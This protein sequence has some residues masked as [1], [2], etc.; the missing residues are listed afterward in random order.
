[1]N[2]TFSVYNNSL[3]AMGGWRFLALAMDLWNALIFLPQKLLNKCTLPIMRKRWSSP[4]DLNTKLD[5]EK[6]EPISCSKEARAKVGGECE[7]KP[8]TSEPDD[9]IRLE[10]TIINIINVVD[11]ESDSQ[12]RFY[13]SKIIKCSMRI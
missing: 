4:F 1:V 9:N 6:E 2:S 8:A 11:R 12:N 7:T 10:I 13:F 5:E 3:V